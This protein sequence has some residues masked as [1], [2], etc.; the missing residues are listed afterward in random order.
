MTHHP[1]PAQVSTATPEGEAL[2]SMARRL[3]SGAG[4]AT[5]RLARVPT[6]SANVPVL[7]GQEHDGTTWVVT[8]PDR[9]HGWTTEDLDGTPSVVISITEQAPFADHA[10][11]TAAVLV[12]G[13]A[14]LLPVGSLPDTSDTECL[15]LAQTLTDW[16]DARILRIHIDGVWARDLFDSADLDPEDVQRAAVDRL[17]AD[18]ATLVRLLSATHADEL[19][20]IAD[21][22]LG[23]DGLT[24]AILPVSADTCGITTLCP[25][26]VPPRIVRIPFNTP[27]DS[28]PEALACVDHLA[29]CARGAQGGCPHRR[30]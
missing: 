19:A 14:T 24:E 4:T 10:L 9:L 30:D 28:P 6:C 12:R 8:D 5:L 2:P 13:K 11:T 16:P 27:V 17:A 3:L 25:R 20:L 7:H 29:W 21:L 22:C 23:R 15:M 1:D 18:S 26:A